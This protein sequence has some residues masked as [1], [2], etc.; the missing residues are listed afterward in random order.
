MFYYI[1]HYYYILLFLYAR[2][3][4]ILIAPLKFYIL[5]IKKI[6]L[7]IFYLF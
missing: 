2:Y 6:N 4:R 7:S 1:L 3:L 5:K